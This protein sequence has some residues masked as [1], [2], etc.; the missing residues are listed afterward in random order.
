[1]R[2]THRLL[3]LPPVLLLAAPAFAVYKCQADGKVSYSDIPCPSGNG[4]RLDAAKAPDAGE[5]QRRLARDKAEAK[6]LEA[7]RHKREAQESAQ[8]RTSAH[9]LEKQ[10]KKCAQ[11]AQRKQWAA[12]DAARAGVK[13]ADKMQ[14]KARRAEQQFQQECG[15]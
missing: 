9:V 1:M 15:A 6:R 5:A 7:E 4:S 10:E 14:R 2:I 13:S 8:R 12:E 11:L 3:L